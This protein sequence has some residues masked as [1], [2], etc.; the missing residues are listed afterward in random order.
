MIDHNGDFLPF[1]TVGVPIFAVFFISLI[2]AIF[3]FYKNS[4]DRTDFWLV[5][6][7]PIVGVVCV[8]VASLFTY[9]PFTNDYL[10]LQT[11]TGKVLTVDSRFMAASQYVVITYDTNLTVRCDDARC[12][13]VKPGDNIRLLCHKEHQWGSPLYTDGWICRWGS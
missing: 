3:F 1:V 9:Y 2:I 13:T 5:A 6:T 10:R 11:V 12:V 7:L 4:M 8:V